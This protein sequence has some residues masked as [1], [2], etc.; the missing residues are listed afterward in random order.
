[1]AGGEEGSCQ[2]F[3]RVVISQLKQEVLAQ[4]LQEGGAEQVG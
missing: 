4:L 3:T 1:V 2:G